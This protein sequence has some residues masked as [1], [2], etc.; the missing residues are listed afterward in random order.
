MKFMRY[1]N[2]S[3]FGAGVHN[4]FGRTDI[5]YRKLIAVREPQTERVSAAFTHLRII[6]VRATL[7]RSYPNCRGFCWNVTT[8]SASCSLTPPILSP[9]G[10]IASSDIMIY[11]C[12]MRSD[13]KM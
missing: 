8:S 13:L 6:V 11:A 5:P 10:Y 3:A 2:T 4:I 7:P 1:E 12:S 9:A